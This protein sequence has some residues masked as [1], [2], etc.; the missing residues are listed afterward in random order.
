M[1]DG[2]V[3]PAYPYDRLDELRAIADQLPGG[4][5][6]C[7]IGAP[8]DPPPPFVIDALDSQEA[9]TII[10]A[11]IELGHRLGLKV[12]AEGV[13][14]KLTAQWLAQLQCD[15]GQGNYFSAPLQSADFLKWIADWSS[16]HA[17]EE[18]HKRKTTARDSDSD[19]VVSMSA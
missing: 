2:F 13:E 16:A 6:D 10:H 3:P 7:S 14:D 15:V 11:T 18:T 19:N 9:A 5:V 4:A 8:C 17:S 12:V 1:T